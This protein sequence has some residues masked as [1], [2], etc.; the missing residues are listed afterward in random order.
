[1]GALAAG[2][3]ARAA[4]ISMETWLGGYGRSVSA[5][6]PAVVARVREMT[7]HA[8]LLVGEHELPNMRAM[9]DFLAHRIARAQRVEFPNTAHWLN[10][11][12]PDQ[13]NQPV[14]EFLAAHPL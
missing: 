11:E 14:L 4:E 9:V 13:F 6:S 10:V 7:E 5:V 3:F 1:V 8:L 12:Y 2:D